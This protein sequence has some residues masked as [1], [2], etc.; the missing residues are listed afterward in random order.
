MIHLRE[1]SRHDLPILNRWR[2][3]PDLIRML[4]S[5][6]LFIAPEIDERWF[7][8]YCGQRD[9]AVR[10]A[11]VTPDGDEFIGCVNLTNIHPINRSAEFSIM[12]GTEQHRGKGIGEL[13]TKQMLRHG[14]D[15]LNLARIYLYAVSYNTRAI[16]LYRRIGFQMEG[17]LRAALFKN[18]RFEDEV[19][20]SMLRDEYAALPWRAAALPK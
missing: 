18:G 7:D 15:D 11:I 14:F 17:T 12:I 16:E 2:N 20:M 1:L 10:L 6:F 3:D 13:A 8:Q 19:L 5:N 9:R 4:G